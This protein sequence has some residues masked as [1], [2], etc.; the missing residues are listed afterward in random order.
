VH[1]P[2]C[3]TKC[4]YC[5][6]YSVTR[7]GEED[8]WLASLGRE[9]ALYRDRFSRFDSLY[10]GG[11]TPTC[12][13][14]RRMAA[15]FQ[16]LHE[17]FRFSAHAEITMEANPDDINGRSAAALK[18]LGINRL[19]LGIQSFDDG[20]LAFL[21]RRHTATGAV[22]AL[23]AV[24]GAGFANIG[25]D[26]MYGLPGQTQDTW[27]ATLDRALSFNPA[28]LSCYQLTP[29]GET[30][31]SRMAGAGQILLPD[32]DEAADLFLLTSRFLE[33]HGFI[34]YEVSNFAASRRLFCRHNQKYWSHADYL[35][36]GPAAHSFD[37]T[38]R[39]WNY[40]SLERYCE[41]LKRGMR[42]VEGEEV[43]SPEQRELER[44]YLGLRTRRGISL[45]SLRKGSLPVVRELKRA[46]LVTIRGGRLRPS[47][48]GY[49][50]ADSL[51][52]L[53]SP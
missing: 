49:L 40:R 48:R 37:G 18:S 38:G 34:H 1:V 11:G 25:I 17:H 27:L 51:P 52:L 21:R 14:E 47:R 44:L 43:L 41:A 20:E 5:D 45:P 6:F 35:G 39:W 24:I 19:S 42:P 26:L 4:I 15:L 22:D 3:R 32:E 46:G 2:F 30:P 9:I 33:A 53:L 10:I 8:A 29:E 28:H 36:L 7:T 12:L 23:E 13:D 16:R 31:L 50:V